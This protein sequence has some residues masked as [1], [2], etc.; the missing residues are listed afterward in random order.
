MVK[1]T[2]FCVLLICLLCGCAPRAREYSAVNTGAAEQ[3]AGVIKATDASASLR[4]VEVQEPPA[5]FAVPEGWTAARDA[6]LY[7][8]ACPGLDATIEFVATARIHPDYTYREELKALKASAKR[9]YTGVETTY[10]DRY[11]VNGDYSGIELIYT[12]TPPG[13]SGRLTSHTVIFFEDGNE[14][15]FALTAG[16]AAYTQAEMAFRDLLFSLEIG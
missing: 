3:T 15:D 6:D 14:Y 5:R 12:Y 4:A 1:R 7:T 13:Q 9:L 11:Y 10:E 16:A 8:L 2:V